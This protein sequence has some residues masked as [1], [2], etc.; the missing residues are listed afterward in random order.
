MEE[1]W[2]SE[3]AKDITWGRWADDRDKWTHLS[4][5]PVLCRSKLSEVL[6]LI[7]YHDLYQ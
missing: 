3:R 1:E 2:N 4:Q 6:E 5:G 7:T